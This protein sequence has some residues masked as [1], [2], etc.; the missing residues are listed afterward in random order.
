MH[1][2][3]ANLA[4]C[5]AL[6]LIACRQADRAP[7][8]R[9][10]P[11]PLPPTAA[12]PERAPSWAT[13]VGKSIA[14]AS[15]LSAANRV[16]PATMVDRAYDS[17]EQVGIRRLVYRVS[18]DIPQ[19][20]RAPHPPML[21]LQ[22]EL[23]LDVGDERL[24]ARFTGPGWPVD[25]GSEVRLRGDLPGV[26]LFDGKGGRPVAPA[27]LSSWF[28]GDEGEHPSR[29]PIQLRA[30][31]GP[32]A[33]GPSRLVC[34][35]L[36]EWTS[37]PRDDL[38]RWC[39]GGV[40]MQGFRFGIWIAEL[41]AIVPMTLP[42]SMLRA[43]SVGSPRT[44]T[45]NPAVRMLVDARD[46]SRLEPIVVKP[47]S[48]LPAIDAGSLTTAG[49]TAVNR[50]RARM[51]VVVSGVALAWLQPGAATEFTGFAPGYY[52]V[53]AV[54]PYAQW[55]GGAGPIV[56]PGDLIINPN[57]EAQ[58]ETPRPTDSPEAAR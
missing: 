18:I 4:V 42:R 55:S 3:R 38:E 28:V 9:V 14:K 30:A 40:L 53:G 22:M 34:S 17:D 12:E 48:D 8:Q 20:L 51:L 49:L 19:G 27:H 36:A 5:T 46:I 16:Q 31:N 39:E 58:L 50:S 32:S 29:V 56:L 11:N 54:R 43:D 33:E 41:T 15:Q 57:A 35:L 1:F 45:P 47:K 23:L 13:E 21:P 2:R 24:R 10:A 25:D 7:V 52:R 37:Q 26:Y 6:A 44:P